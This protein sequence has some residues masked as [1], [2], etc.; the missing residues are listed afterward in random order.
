MVSPQRVRVH[1]SHINNVTCHEKATPTARWYSSRHVPATGHGFR[2]RQRLGKHTTF[3]KSGP[4]PC[5]RATMCGGRSLYMLPLAIS[6]LYSGHLLCINIRDILY[7]TLAHPRH[8]YVQ[9]D[10]HTVRAH[11]SLKAHLP[12]QSCHR[13]HMQEVHTAQL[14]RC[15][16]SYLQDRYVSILTLG[17]RN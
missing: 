12:R 9:Y 8:Y 15:T 11:H 6:R 17:T 1:L 14:A 16:R 4:L 3:C 13:S 5:V 7:T 10:S 2:S